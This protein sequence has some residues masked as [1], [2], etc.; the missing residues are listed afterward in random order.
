LRLGAEML[1]AEAATEAG[2][3]Y[4]AILPYPEPDRPWS[5][6]NRARFAG[7]LR[8]ARSAVTL[9][10][11]RPDSRPKFRDALSRRDGWLIA[12]VDE[13]VLVWDGDDPS[14]R[15]LNRKLVKRLGEEEVWV[16]EP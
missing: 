10:R 9:E 3:P 1:A 4:V 14:L 8:S 2:V 15:D 5:E 12:N 7:L 6:E 11:A 16:L 13:A